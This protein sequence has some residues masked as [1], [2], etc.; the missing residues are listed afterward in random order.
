MQTEPR[1]ARKSPTATI[2]PRIANGIPAPPASARAA[3]TTAPPPS[4]AAE[5]DSTSA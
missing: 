5:S 4:A 1:T 2:A 3:R